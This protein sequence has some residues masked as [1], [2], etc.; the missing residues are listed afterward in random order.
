MPGMVALKHNKAI[1]AMKERPEANGKAPKQI[2]C[3]AMRKLL[4]FVY[5]VLNVRT[6]I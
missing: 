5:G 6:A 4:H 2:I 1:K 3:A